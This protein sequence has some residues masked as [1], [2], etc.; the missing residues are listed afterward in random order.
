M[1][2]CGLHLHKC[3]YAYC[4][5]VCV[6]NHSLLGRDLKQPS[7]QNFSTPAIWWNHLEHLK[8]LILKLVKSKKGLCSDN[9]MV[10]TSVSCLSYWTIVT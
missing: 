10:P 9:T 1:C 5:C 6:Q 4:V 3:M 2:E 7:E 8:V